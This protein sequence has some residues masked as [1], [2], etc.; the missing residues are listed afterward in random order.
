MP[1]AEETPGHWACQGCWA[2]GASGL[3][4]AAG[5]PVGAQQAR[6]PGLC[7]LG[8]LL[9]QMLKPDPRRRLA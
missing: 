9:S 8:L 7:C 4:A 2:P 5:Q 3:R 6:L 1:S